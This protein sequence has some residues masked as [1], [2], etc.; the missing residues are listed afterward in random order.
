MFNSSMVFFYFRQSVQLPYNPCVTSLYS[1]VMSWRRTNNHTSSKN[2]N[3]NHKPPTQQPPTSNSKYNNNSNANKNTAAVRLH[4]LLYLLVFFYCAHHDSSSTGGDAPAPPLFL[5]GARASESPDRDCCDNPQYTS[6]DLPPPQMFTTIAP[7]YRTY[8][9]PEQPDFPDLP[10]VPGKLCV[11]VG[12]KI[13]YQT[14]RKAA[15]LGM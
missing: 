14:Y 12:K 9:P 3:V 8:E 15:Y 1:E 10:E 7:P 5:P 11:I 6:F 4:Q 2:D 13:A